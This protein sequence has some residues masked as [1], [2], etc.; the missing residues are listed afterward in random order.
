MR[1]ILARAAVQGSDP[2]AGWKAEQV[3]LSWD[4]WTPDGFVVTVADVSGERV[5]AR[6]L[7]RLATAI[8]AR[9]SKE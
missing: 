7:A 3:G 8:A 1:G 2:L 9:G 4:V 5:A 6:I